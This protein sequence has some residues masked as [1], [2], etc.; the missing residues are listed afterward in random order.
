LRSGGLD[1]I[2][3]QDQ[4]EAALVRPYTGYYRRL[5]LKAAVIIQSFACGHNFVDGNKRTAMLLADLA[6]R[7]SRYALLPV[8]DENL[9]DSFED[10]IVALV[11]RQLVLA[12]VIAWFKARLHRG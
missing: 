5:E 9:E 2:L 11:E 8:A 7:K 12:D 1:G 6:I 3:H 10:M 4:L